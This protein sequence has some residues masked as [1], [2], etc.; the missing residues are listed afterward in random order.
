LCEVVG[1]AGGIAFEASIGERLVKSHLEAREAAEDHPLPS[2]RS[3]IVEITV[4]ALVDVGEVVGLVVEE[5]LSGG[6][7]VAVEPP[8]V[9][10]PGDGE[11]EFGVVG[12]AGGHLL[13]VDGRA[14]NFKNEAGF[15]PIDIGDATDRLKGMLELS[16]RDQFF[17][18]LLS[19][20]VKEAF[21]TLPAAGCAPAVVEV[22][23]P[24]LAGAEADCLATF[25]AGVV[26]ASPRAAGREHHAEVVSSKNLHIEM[27]ILVASVVQALTRRGGLRTLSLTNTY[28]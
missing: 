8:V 27:L 2:D 15:R 10:D 25:E 12:V 21:A 3:L 6:D 5:V 23:Y 13:G 24:P 19:S 28:G 14:L 7:V 16:I 4:P 26:D 22:A 18:S 17:E 1:E 20:E 9:E 11:A